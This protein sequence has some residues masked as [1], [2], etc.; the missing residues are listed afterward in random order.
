MEVN[1]FMMGCYDMYFVSGGYV[2]DNYVD[3][4][5]NVEIVYFFMIGVLGV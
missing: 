4:S 3:I 5:V 1:C 2:F